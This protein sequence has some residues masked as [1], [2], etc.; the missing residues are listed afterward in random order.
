M[1]WSLVIVC[2][3]IF[4]DEFN[5]VRLDKYGEMD[6]LEMRETAFKLDGVKTSVFN[7]GVRTRSKERQQSGQQVNFFKYNK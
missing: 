7:T 2:I 5:E 6:K 4:S 1:D 3:Q